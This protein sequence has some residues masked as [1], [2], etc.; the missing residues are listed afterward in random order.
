[1]YRVTASV[2]ATLEL[3]CKSASIA[4]IPG[5]HIVGAMFLQKTL[6]NGYLNRA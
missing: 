5:A 3:I 1:M 2:L 6:A 4:V